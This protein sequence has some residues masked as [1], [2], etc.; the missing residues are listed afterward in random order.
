MLILLYNIYKYFF[1]N[2]ILQ[3]SIDKIYQFTCCKNVESFCKIY[4]NY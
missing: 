2:I 4:F 3:Q 1:N